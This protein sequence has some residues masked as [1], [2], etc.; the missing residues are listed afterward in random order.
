MCGVC[1]GDNSTCSEERKFYN[2]TEPKH[3]YNIIDT[4]PAGSWD[5]DIRQYSFSR[6][7]DFNY[8]GTFYIILY[9]LYFH[10]L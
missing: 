4:I 2:V 8:L 10:L 3:G 9:V 1:A 7:E 6:K 5:L